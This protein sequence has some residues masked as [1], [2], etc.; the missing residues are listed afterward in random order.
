MERSPPTVTAQAI[1]AEAWRRGVELRAEGTRVL[2]RPKIAV[3]ADLLAA[4][5]DTRAELA[6]YLNR[7][8]DKRVDTW[9]P[10]G[11][12]TR[13]CISCGGGLQPTDT[14]GALCFSCRWSES[15]H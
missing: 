8:K 11:A 3:D 15:V 13:T 2:Y 7:L 9:Q 10:P 12:I 6:A 14:D 4:M 5:R 1:V